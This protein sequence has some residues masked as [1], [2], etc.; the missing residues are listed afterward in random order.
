MSDWW[1]S[2]SVVSVIRTFFDEAV[3]IEETSDGQ[4]N[5]VQP[6]KIHR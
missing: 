5:D 3:C 2:R 4:Q 1:A 6:L